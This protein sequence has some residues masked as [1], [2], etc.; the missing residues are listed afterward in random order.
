L[1]RDLYIVGEERRTAS[2]RPSKPS[3]K[4]TMNS[5]MAKIKL[6]VKAEE[7]LHL[8]QEDEE[9]IYLEEGEPEELTG[10]AKNRKNNG[11]NSTKTLTAPN[12]F[13]A[14]NA[15]IIRGL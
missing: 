14:W 10:F 4:I 6:G 11:R 1:G 15:P 8:Q 2:S 7:V 5:I 9:R 12:D 13:F 3:F